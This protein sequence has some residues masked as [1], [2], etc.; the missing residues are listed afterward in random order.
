MNRRARRVTALTALMAGLIVHG[1][2]CSEDANGLVPDAGRDGAQRDDA[3]DPA[4]AA[5]R[6]AVR[7]DRDRTA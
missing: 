1:S 3:A 6:H 4:L 5:A 2:G 7:S